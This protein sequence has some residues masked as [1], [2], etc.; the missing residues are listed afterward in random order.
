MSDPEML[1]AKE[2]GPEAKLE[3]VENQATRM[4]EADKEATGQ[5]FDKQQEVKEQP[6]AIGYWPE[7]YKSLKEKIIED[8]QKW[9]LT[10]YF[11]TKMPAPEYTDKL[12]RQEKPE[13]VEGYLL[14]YNIRQIENNPDKPIEEILLI[15]KDKF[16]ENFK[17]EMLT[18]TEK[19][20]KWSSE[21]INRDLETQKIGKF[22]ELPQKSQGEIKGKFDNFIKYNIPIGEIKLF[23]YADATN[24]SEIWERA[25]GESWEE[26]AKSA[27]EG[28]RS[29][30]IEK[31]LDK[32][33]LESAKDVN[34]NVITFSDNYFDGINELTPEQKQEKLNTIFAYN[35]A[36]MQIAFLPEEQIKYIN[37]HITGISISLDAKRVWEK[38]FVGDK[39]TWGRIETAGSSPERTLITEVKKLLLKKISINHINFVLGTDDAGSQLP[40]KYRNYK[41]YNLGWFGRGRWNEESKPWT[42]KN[43]YSR[44]TNNETRS[45]EIKQEEAKNNGNVV[46]WP[47]GIL[48]V[49]LDPREEGMETKDIVNKFSNFHSE[50]NME[51]RTGQFEDFNNA[52]TEAMERTTNPTLKEQIKNIQILINMC[53]DIAKISPD[54]QVAWGASEKK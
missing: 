13:T 22:I 50:D 32:K 53:E 39:F 7:E 14:T 34:W 25:E 27:F 6:E 19:R 54:I 2:Q 46:M 1:Q 4:P 10:P 11:N 16:M 42:V 49:V 21:T 33:R 31:W 28:L 15:D 45:I 26:H 44:W 24:I 43:F 47:K 20:E 17:K 9:R 29:A 5:D 23:W 8:I 52:L 41:F 40:E 35:R 38:E 48:W 30:L 18:W 3:G 12:F 51:M 37:S 36:L